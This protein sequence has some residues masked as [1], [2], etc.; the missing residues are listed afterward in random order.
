MLVGMAASTTLSLSFPEADIAVLALD[1]PESSAN[2][3]SSQVLDA[4]EQHLNE[5]DRRKKLAGL[6]IHSAKPGMF[7]AGAD[8][9]EFAAWI[10]SPK[11][12]VTR[13]CQRGQQLFGRLASCDYV[14]VA[15]I[16]GICVGGGAE[17]AMWCD[18]RIMTASEKTAYGFPEVKLGL[19]PGWG[20]T[21]RTPRMVGLANAVELVTGGENIDARTAALMGLAQEVVGE[22]VGEAKPR[23]AARVGDGGIDDPREYKE[24]PAPNAPHSDRLVAAAIR[25]IRAEQ[26]SQRFR[27]DRERWSKPIEISETELGFLG[28]TASAYIQQQTKGHYPA[29]LAALELMLGAALVNLETACRMEAEEFAKLFGSPINRALLNVFFLRDRNK[30]DP[31]VASDVKPRLISSAGVAGAGVMGQGIAAANVKR[32]IPTAI[33]DANQDALARG[34][35]G[36]LSEVSYNREIKGPDVKRAVELAPLVNGTL[37]DIE[38]CHSDVI[39]EAIFEDGEAKKH[40]FARLEPLMRDEALLCSNTST[41]PITRLAEGLERPERFCGLHFFNPVRSMPLVEVIRGARTSDATI[42]TA[43]VYAKRLG[44]SPIVMNDGPGFLVNR[45][46][47]P[48][49][50]EAAL[51]LCEGVEISAIERA[52]KKFGMP[53][54]PITLFDVVGLDVAVHAGRTMLEAFPERVVAAPILEKLAECGRLGQKAGRG[55]YDYGPAKA[56]KPPR[57]EESAEVARLIEECRSGPP[58]KFSGEELTDR[59]FLP[60]LVEATRALEDGIVKDVRDVDL[61]LIYGIGFPP[62]LGGL[63]FW[64]DQVGVAKLVVKL[65]SY[66][67]L[68]KRFEP[69]AMLTKIAESG[70]KFYD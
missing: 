58:R 67:S 41:I 29:P 24:K 6:V 50:N 66:S 56:G 61:A 52:A 51:L 18:R 5:L 11:E 60:M 20:G 38:L 22:R 31:G 15:A 27:R 2:I 64:A 3:L 53:M 43:V 46:L 12:D 28:A 23:P 37:F 49:M 40:L 4:L 30:K 36:V 19:F 7:I 10:D 35:G 47:L 39:I 59:L 14:T 57:G 21:A 8:L 17:L 34:I 70:G 65:R 25:M 54:G 32:G 69:T 45:L 68:G 62:F 55:F 26:A 33:M 16:D 63:F 44:K 42:A 1:D 9:K 48:Y 13:F